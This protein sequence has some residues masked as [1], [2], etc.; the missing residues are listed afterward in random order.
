MIETDNF[1]KVEV[2]DAAA[3]WAWLDTHHGQSDSVWLVTWKKPSPNYVSREQVLDALIAFGWIDGIRRKLDDVQTMQLISPR[4]QQAWAETYRSRADRL[5]AEGRMMP[6]GE[7]AITDA[8]ASGRWDA[9]A[10]VD[11]LAVPSDLDAALGTDRAD[12]DGL[13]PSYRRN[14]LRWIAGAKKPET[15]AKR[16]ETAV[17]ATRRGEKLRNM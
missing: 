16:V 11:T 17:A 3:L 14:V 15:R 5:R 8:K 12:W 2:P 9:M 7:R 13:A 4:Q 10:E 6:P 1:T